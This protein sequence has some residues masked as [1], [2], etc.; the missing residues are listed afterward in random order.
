MRSTA[1]V[2]AVCLLVG[3]LALSACTRKSTANKKLGTDSGSGT[4][5]PASGAA[6]ASSPDFGSLTNVCGPNKTGKTLTATD[7]GV[8]AD[9]IKLTT[10]SDPGFVGRPGLNQELFDASTVFTKWCNSFGGINGRKIIDN[11][12]DA[13]IVNYKAKVLEACQGDF[14]MVGGGAVFD[15]TGQQARLNCLLPDIPAYVVSPQARGAELVV[16]PLPNALD[17]LNIGADRYVTAK[18]PGTTSSVGYLTANVPSTVVV[19]KQF[20]EGGAQIGWKTVYSQQYNA[21]GETT[22][23]PFAQSMKSKNVQGLVFVGEAANLAKLEQAFQSLSYYPKWISVSANFYDKQ[24]ITLGGGALKNT[25]VQVLKVPFFDAAQSPAMTKYLS[26][27]RTYLPKGKA[28]AVL[29]VDSFSAWLLFAKAATKCGADL[30]RKCMY[31]NAASVSAWDGG[32]LT[33]PANPAKG[34]APIC[35]TM[36]QATPAGFVAVDV[37]PNLGVFNCNPTNRVELHGNYGQGATLAS[38][39]KSMSDLP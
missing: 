13:A 5:A 9:S 24:L 32:G 6:A 38:V 29:G 3:L 20:E 36:V 26:L 14:S 33:A 21:N 16:Q 19:Q 15:D 7:R 27:F 23:V 10:V 2:V 18:Y 25:Y 35:Y 31:D 1:R 37:K 22:W 12:R 28:Q 11:Q 4:T 8:T 30:T 39:G 34:K 17:N